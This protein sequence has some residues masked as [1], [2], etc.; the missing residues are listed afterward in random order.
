L[1]KTQKT[2]SVWKPSAQIVFHNLEKQNQIVISIR[3]RATAVG[4][5]EVSAP[6]FLY[7]GFY[8]NGNMPDCQG[9]I[10]SNYCKQEAEMTASVTSASCFLLGCFLRPTSAFMHKGLPAEKENA[11]CRVYLLI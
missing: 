9:G 6:P 1:L 7:I 4:I 8:C 10:P 5:H 2:Q 3:V 11:K